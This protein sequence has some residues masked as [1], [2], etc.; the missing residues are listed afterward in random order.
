MSPVVLPEQRGRI[1]C[2]R[3]STPVSLWLLSCRTARVSVQFQGLARPAERSYRRVGMQAG[4]QMPG[5]SAEH[6]GWPTDAASQQRL[7]SPQSPTPLQHTVDCSGSANN[8]TPQSITRTKHA[9]SSALLSRIS[10]PSNGTRR[11]PEQCRGQVLQ[12]QESSS[13]PRGSILSGR[14][15]LAMGRHVPITAG[16]SLFGAGSIE[17]PRRHS[18]CRRG[19]RRLYDPSTRKNVAPTDPVR[20]GRRHHARRFGRVERC[21]SA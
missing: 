6:G 20:L 3:Q 11:A 19:G 14:A 12:A 10:V 1:P 18:A 9:T 2:R 15:L 8:D 5:A 13:Q 17:P 7:L 4:M 16:C 21:S